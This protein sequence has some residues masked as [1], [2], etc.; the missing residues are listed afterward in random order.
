MADDETIQFNTRGL[1][2]FIRTLKGKSPVARVGVLSANNSRND[3]GKNAA[4]GAAHEYGTSKLPIRSFLRVP[5][6]DN[7]Q[8]YLDQSGAFD[9]DALEKVVR[10]G[11]LKPWVQKVGFIA[12]TIVSDAFKTGGFGKWKPSNMKDKKVMQTLVETNQLRESISSE[13]K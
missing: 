6:S 10:E 7:L 2:A 1:D 12:E 5:I 3:N 11:S 13:V 8:K 4:I 9:K